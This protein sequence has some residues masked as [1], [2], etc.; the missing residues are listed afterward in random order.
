MFVSDFYAK[1]KIQE[2]ISPI[3]LA[4]LLYNSLDKK[5]PEAVRR[6]GHEVV[7]NMIM[8]YAEDVQSIRSM[9]D[10]DIAVDEIMDDLANFR[11]DKTN[12]LP[13][14]NEPTKLPANI[15]DDD[16][17]VIDDQGGIVSSHS[18]SAYKPPFGTRIIELENGQRAMRGLTMKIEAPKGLARKNTQPNTEPPL[19][20]NLRKWFKEKWVRFGPDGKIRGACARGDE[21]EGKPKCLPQAKAHALGKKGRKYAASKKRREDPN[22]ERRGPAKNVAT[23][24]KSNEDVSE[25]REGPMREIL[26]KM[27]PGWPDYVIKDWISS[28]VKNE[29][30]LKDLKGWLGELNKQVVPNSWKLHQKMQLTFDMLSPKTR[31][32]MKTKRQFGARNPFMIPRDEERS[33]DAEQLIKSK[34]MHNLPPVIM[35]QHANGLELCEGWHRTMAAFRLNPNGF[36]VNAWI[37]QSAEQGVAEAAG[38]YGPFTVT[39]NTGERP[40]SRTKTKKFRREDDAILWAQDW[41]DDFP[42]Y[43][44]ATAE[45]TDPEGNVVWTTDESLEEQ[46]MAEAFGPLPKDN[47]QIRLG[48]HTVEIERVGLKK[49]YIGFAW[50]DSQGQEHY[51]EVA[52]GDLGSYDDL[53]ARIKDEIQYQERRLKQGMAG[54]S[55]EEGVNDP[56]IFKCIFLFGPMGAGKSTVAGPLL[57]HTGLRSVNLDNFNEMFIKK[58]QVPTGHLSPDQLEKSWQ[59]SQIQQQNF[60]DG[61][62]GIII[63]GS[64]RNPETALSVIKKLKQLGYEFMMIFVNVSEA[65]SIARQQSRANKQQQQWGVGR[66]VDITTAKDTYAQVQQNLAQYKEYFGPQRFVYVDNENT[67]DLTQ[68]TKQIDAFLRAPVSRPEALAWIQAQKGGQ[69]VAQQQQ[70]VATSTDRQQQALAR[71]Q[72]S[73]STAEFAKQGVAEGKIKLSTD[74]N[75]YGAEVG[76]YKASGPVFNVHPHLLVGFEPDDKMNQ[77]KSKANVEKI[78]AGLKKGSKLPPLLVRKYKDGYQVLDGHHRFW[79]YKLLGVKSIPVQVVPAKDIEEIGKQTVTEAVDTKSLDSATVRR[80]QNYLNKEFDAN[81]DV[82]G[83]LGPLTLKS[84]K[85]YIPASRKKPAPYPQRTTAVQGNELKEQQLDEKCWPG[86]KKKGMKTMFGKR[87]PNCVKKEDIEKQQCP[88]CGG[89]MF[90]SLLINEKKDACYYKVKSRYKVWPSAYASGALVQCRKKGAGNWGS[91]TNETRFYFTVKATLAESLRDDFAMTQD[92][93][94]WYISEDQG[95]AKILEAQRAFGVPKIKEVKLKEVRISD[96]TGRAGTIGDDNTASPIGSIAKRGKK[97]A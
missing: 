41:L 16:W 75:W 47:K 68:A 3:D 52:V 54:N 19:K 86:Y 57:S 21:S 8:D 62:L 59:L 34:G 43:S 15:N 96:Y 95:P 17:Y 63:D 11:G 12:E 18:P 85:K 45:V 46:G 32:M 40:Q 67:P 48:R 27:L 65:T 82:D 50:H 83:E 37:G 4:E 88:E 97:H 31:Y 23:K 58:G 25:A 39:I 84:I 42:Q 33:A 2:S 77:P 28:R 93:D 60:I 9:S 51:E 69:Q 24:K 92:R 14:D 61:R 94:G 91:K 10:V 81:L 78:V 6:Y 53:L 44:F 89:P 1:N 56:H 30:D 22:P 5:Y 73:L 64:G 36:L 66:Q 38:L 72:Q 76:D 49:N 13:A 90:S 70:K 26:R 80:I 55:L 87:Y 79:A 35:L 29:Q 20:E 7:G 74:P 71:Y